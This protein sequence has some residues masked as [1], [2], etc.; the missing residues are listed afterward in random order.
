MFSFLLFYF[1]MIIGDNMEARDIYSQLVNPLD[2]KDIMDA[3][4]E[5]YTETQKNNDDY[6]SKIMRCSPKAHTSAHRIADQD[7]L[8]AGLFNC[9]KDEVVSMTKEEY[10]KGNY[11]PDFIVLR[12]FVKTLPKMKTEKEYLDAIYNSGNDEVIDAYDKYCWH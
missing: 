3:L 5:K 10:T 6:Y 12:N 11:D 1:I 7:K 4:I 9:W 8:R 2:N